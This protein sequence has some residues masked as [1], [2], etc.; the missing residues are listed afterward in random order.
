MDSTNSSNIDQVNSDISS[1]QEHHTLQK[2]DSTEG[3]N[4]ARRH[5]SS[6]VTVTPERL[7]DDQCYWEGQHQKVNMLYLYPKLLLYYDMRHL[8]L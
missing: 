6:T 4:V 2:H 5:I 7:V 3:Q 1:P 8:I